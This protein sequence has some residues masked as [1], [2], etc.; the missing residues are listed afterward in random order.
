MTDEELELLERTDHIYSKYYI[1]INW[2]FAILAEQR[3]KE[4]IKTDLFL[5]VL[6]QEIRI[7]RGHLQALVNY[8]WVP[9]P[10]SYPQVVY[11][12]VRVYFA[13]C[14]ISRQHHPVSLKI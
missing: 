12:A 14:I 3:A 6:L 9:V 7:F 5:N 1:P 8:D 4:K 2:T 11:L 10:L 13:V